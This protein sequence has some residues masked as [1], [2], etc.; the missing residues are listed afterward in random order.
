MRILKINR[1]KSRVPSKS[2]YWC[3]CD[4]AGWVKAENAPRCGH[5]RKSSKDKK[6]GPAPSLPQD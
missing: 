2:I 3:G 1:L 4:R 6:P 5:T